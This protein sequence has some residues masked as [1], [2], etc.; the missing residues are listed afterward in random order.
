MALG[1]SSDTVVAT[2]AG[3]TEAFPYK[4]L[5]RHT[6]NCQPMETHKS[7]SWA[8][9]REQDLG[10]DAPE[11]VSN[12]DS[13]IGVQLMYIPVECQTGS[14][15]QIPATGEKDVLEKTDTVDERVKTRKT[16]TVAEDMEGIEGQ[17][18]TLE[19]KALQRDI[20]TLSVA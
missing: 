4:R 17:R 6:S 12:H 20:E 11:V 15:M 5:D 9:A 3:V 18:E 1:S 10:N 2:V 13:T 16:K 19:V 8:S 14:L 7:R